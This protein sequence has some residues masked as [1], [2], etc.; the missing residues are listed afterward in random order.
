M[1]GWETAKTEAALQFV[2]NIH[3][4][5][6][7][8][9]KSGLWA[10]HKLSGL[11]KDS[12]IVFFA[13]FLWVMFSFAKDSPNAA[14]EGIALK[15]EGLNCL[16]PNKSDFEN[17]IKKLFVEHSALRLMKLVDGSVN[18]MWCTLVITLLCNPP[19]W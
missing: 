14:A 15:G 5:L 1:F 7:Y 18:A 12:P 19:L 2:H 9:L 13:D 4:Q 17:G 10:I 11:T 16:G 6:G 3:Y 8:M